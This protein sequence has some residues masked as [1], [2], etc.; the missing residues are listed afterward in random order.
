MM[1]RYELPFIISGRPLTGSQHGTGGWVN[2]STGYFD[3][4]RIPLIRGR[5]ITDVDAGG[6]PGVVV[7]NETMARRFWPNEDPLKDRLLIGQGFA[8]AE[9]PARQIVGIVGDVRDGDLTSEPVP[10]M[11]VPTAQMTDGYTSLHSRMPMLW[12][13]RTDVGLSSLIPSI[14]RELRSAS[15]GVPVATTMIRSMDQVMS[16][17]T[18]ASDFQMALMTTFAVAALLLAAVGVYGVTGYSVQRRTQEIGIRLALGAGPLQVRNMVLAQ[19]MTLTLLGVALGIA[20]AFGVTSLLSG[21][22]FGVTPRDPTVFVVVPVLLAAVALAATWL[23]AR[24]ATRVD[25][26]TALRTE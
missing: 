26:M 16:E 20:S 21:F 24:R 6:A 3:V 14:D 8:P 17:S 25:P 23:P 13:V 1:G 4:F 22:L 9:E 18:A 10:M 19:G 11:Y 12:F 2:V 7:I 15:G 5:T